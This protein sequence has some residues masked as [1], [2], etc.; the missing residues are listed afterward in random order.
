MSFDLT[1]LDAY[2]EDQ[3]F[4]LLAQ[5]QAV[6]SLADYATIQTGIKKSSHLQFLN[7]DCVFQSDTCSRTAADTTALSQKTITVGA[8]Q[9]NE[10]LCTKDLNGYWAQTMV[11]KGAR[12]E[13]VIPGAIESVWMGDKINCIQNQLAIADWQGDLTSATNN[14]SYYDG[15]LVQ[16][17]AD[18]TVID[19]NP[20]GITTGTGI[21]VDNIIPILQG[22]WAAQPDLLMGKEGVSCFM[23]WDTYQLYVNALVN[24]NLFHFKG[25]DG[26][27][28]LHGTNVSL[29]PQTGLTGT[30]RI[31][32]TPAKNLVVGMDGEGD[33]DNM[34]VW[35]SKDDRVNKMNIA[36]KRGTQ[37]FYGNEV[38]SFALV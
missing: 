24:A 35:Y 22:M 31:I 28:R 16:V 15:V 3:D 1:A 26:V 7:T 18:A 12:G 20:T 36:F 30:N 34:E 9:L 6:G 21:T 38:V 11:A 32:L 13:E 4:P 25:E 27:T 29:I 5:M 23:G 14:L 17:D 8:I 10:D 37:Y 33:E 2:I 19:G